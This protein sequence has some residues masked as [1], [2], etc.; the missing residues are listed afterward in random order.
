MSIE[1][2][3]YLKDLI[4]KSLYEF[5]KVEVRKYIP[6][7][8]IVLVSVLVLT[9]FFH[10]EFLSNILNLITGT[11]IIF[12]IYVAGVLLLFDKGIEC[13]LGDTS[14][15]FYEDKVAKL[16]QTPEYRRTKYYAIVLIILAVAAVFFSDR[17][18][19]H[20]AFECTTYYVDT[21]KGEFHLEE[22]L[23]DCTHLEDDPPLIP[24]KGYEIKKKDY[25][26]C[27][28]CKDWLDDISYEPTY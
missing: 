14:S 11:S 20:Y 16:K 28:C 21:E 24:M 15:I 6:I 26:F 25:S 2:H 12:V 7:A 13:D 3:S 19:K 27:T 1:S 23:S 22:C 9:F 8:S 10:I 4:G 17:Y 18:R 5:L